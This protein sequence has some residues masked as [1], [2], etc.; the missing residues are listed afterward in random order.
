MPRKN[1]KRGKQY[2]TEYLRKVRASVL[3]YLGNKCNNKACRWL[4]PS[5]VLGCS[6][7]QCL[8]IDHVRGDGSKDRA[9]YSQN[10]IY[11]RILSGKFDKHYQL[12]CANCNWRKLHEN[13]EFRHEF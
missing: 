6:D 12:L 10:Q 3:A 7:P 4:N 11:R 9:R 5:G 8:Q 1:L 2:Q 13:R